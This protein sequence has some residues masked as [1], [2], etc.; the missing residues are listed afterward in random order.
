MSETINPAD[1][2]KAIIQTVMAQGSSKDGVSELWRNEIPLFHLS[3]AQAHLAHHIKTL[4]DP[5]G[6]DG[7]DH[8]ALALTRLAMALSQR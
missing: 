2:S 3:K 1:L 6:F 8:L 5:R 4:Y 7:E